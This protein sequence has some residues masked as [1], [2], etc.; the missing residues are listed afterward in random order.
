MYTF[1]DMQVEV[2][3]V[4]SAIGCTQRQIANLRSLNLG[5]IG[6]KAIFDMTDKS[7]QGRLQRVRHLVEVKNKG[8]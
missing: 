7:F 6:K 3:Q 2:T 8:K 5:R 4:R 1:Y